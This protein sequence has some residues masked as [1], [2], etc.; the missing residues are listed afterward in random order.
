MFWLNLVAKTWN[1]AEDT[2][3]ATACVPLKPFLLVCLARISIHFLSV[4]SSLLVLLLS[5][6]AKF[7]MMAPARE[8]CIFLV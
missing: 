3:C 7:T 6:F 8:N 1:M 2:G 4:L 5:D